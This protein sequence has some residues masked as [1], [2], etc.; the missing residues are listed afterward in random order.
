VSVVERLLSDANTTGFDPKLFDNQSFTLADADTEFLL[1]GID[2]V[3]P[4]EIKRVVSKYRSLLKNKSHEEA[5]VESLTELSNRDETLDISDDT[6]D[7]IEIEDDDELPEDFQPVSD[8]EEVVAG[9]ELALKKVV[10][11]VVTDLALKAAIKKAKQIHENKKAKNIVLPTEVPSQEELVEP[12]ITR[13]KMKNSIKK[14]LLI[15]K[16]R[17]KDW[18]VLALIPII[19]QMLPE[20]FLDEEG[21]LRKDGA[22]DAKRVAAIS[23]VISKYLDKL[24]EKKQQALYQVTKNVVPDDEDSMYDDRE[25]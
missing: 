3:D 14:A 10:A 21:Y 17:A 1:S 23:N 20:L 6:D 8:T 12:L 11:P 19:I 15:M 18:E 16:N 2:P 9:V 25:D 24:D 7:D 5:S 4:L 22:L 13:S